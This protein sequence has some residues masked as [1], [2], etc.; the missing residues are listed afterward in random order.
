LYE[1]FVNTV[2]GNR[3]EIEGKRFI[4]VWWGRDGIGDRFYTDGGQNRFFDTLWWECGR[5]IEIYVETQDEPLTLERFAI[6]ETR[7]P[8]QR[9]STFESSDTRLAEVSPL[10]ERV[11]QMC[12][13]ETYMDCPYFEQLQY[14]GDTRLQ[15][16]VTFA[17]T[18]DDRLPRKALATFDWSRLNFGLTQS[19]Y[20]SRIRQVTRP[21]SIWWV[22]MLHDYAMW[23]DDLPFVAERMF[24]A[25]TVLDS[26]RRFLNEDGL[27]E[28]PY[29]PNF[30]FMDWEPRWSG[31]TPVVGERNINSPANL[32]Y[33]LVLRQTAQ[34]EEWLGE[35]ELAARW[36]RMAN[37]I[38]ARVMEKFW[39][40]ERG[41]VANDLALSSYSEHSQ[42]LALLAQQLGGQWSAGQQKRIGEGLLNA[43]DLHITT[44]YFS[45]Y[46]FETYRLLHRIDRFFGRM[47]G[48]FELKKLG[49]KTTVEMPEPTRSDCHAWGAHPLY[50]YYATLLGIRPAAPGFSKVLIAPQIGELTHISG[51]MPHPRGEISVRIAQNAGAWTAQVVLP[52]GVDGTFQWAGTTHELASGEQEIAL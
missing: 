20:P 3:D 26:Y 50:H 10:M 44:I 47:E 32:Q 41:L 15:V 6:R 43:D 40:E 27:V 30:N 28:L 34:I 2:K 9:E 33:V 8:M 52:D 19:R 49:L 22:A 5:Y 23:R 51:T 18:H 4:T 14:I 24:G 7:Y 12:S 1:D 31:G 36:R 39:N 17:L 25:R 48:W 29:G 13:H 21:F 38:E 35:P 45:H 16:L 37:E 42:C 46:L 11:L